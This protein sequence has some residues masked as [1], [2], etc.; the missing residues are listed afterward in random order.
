MEH[1]NNEFKVGLLNLSGTINGLCK[2]PNIIILLGNYTE[3]SLQRVAKSVNVLKCVKEKIVPQ[4][5]DRYLK[6]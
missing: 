5:K 3:K 4:F 1:Q 2:P 6:M